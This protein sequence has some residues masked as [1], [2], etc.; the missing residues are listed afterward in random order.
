MGSDEHQ[1]ISFFNCQLT[2]SMQHM[3]RLRE[4]RVPLSGAV[5]DIIY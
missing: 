3:A 1:S 4:A 5:H 2:R